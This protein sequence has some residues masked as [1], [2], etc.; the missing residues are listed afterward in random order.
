[1]QGSFEKKVQEKMEELQLTPSVP[2]W[3]KIALQVRPEKKRRRILFWLLLPAALLAGGMWWLLSEKTVEGPTAVEQ[4]IPAIPKTSVDKQAAETSKHTQQKMITRQGQ[5]VFPQRTGTATLPLLMTSSGHQQHTERVHLPNE[6]NA[7]SQRQP[8]EARNEKTTS[9]SKQL[10]LAENTSVSGERANTDNETVP[11]AAVT[12]DTLVQLKAAK[13]K[14]AHPLAGAGSAKKK[15]AVVQKKIAGKILIA[16]GW[17]WQTAA[18]KAGNLYSSPN[19]STNSPG[20]PGSLYQ[21]QNTSAG[22]SLSLGYAVEKALTGRLTLTAGIQY[23]YYSTRQKVGNYKTQ[24][25]TLRFQD[26]DFNVSGYF[27]NTVSGY[28]TQANYTNHFHVAE[29]PV[30]L[31]YQL[32]KQLPLFLTA[33][34]SYGRLLNTNALTYD[35]AAGLLYRNKENNRRNFVNLFAATQFAVVNKKSWKLTVGPV[36]QYNAVPLQK[37]GSR[38]HLLFAGLKTGM[39]F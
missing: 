35:Q 37:T 2:V 16:A 21:P 29:L 31:Q 18:T 23:A 4:T 33:G 13:E 19:Q 12:A 7:Y 11:S 15:A 25:T 22:V 1:M 30:S 5:T 17:S 20:T 8:V 36:I 9:A 27:S 38:S 14:A 24:D 32:V 34:V 10:P 26:K 3:E 39:N 6:I 28:A